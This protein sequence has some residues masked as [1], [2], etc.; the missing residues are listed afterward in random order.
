[1]FGTSASKGGFLQWVYGFGFVCSLVFVLVLAGGRKKQ[2]GT[3]SGYAYKNFFDQSR[4]MGETRVINSP[5]RRKPGR[6][7][8]EKDL[9]EAGGDV[10]DLEAA[11]G[12]VNCF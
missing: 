10:I 1:M 3:P 11:Q 6:P 7:P 9:G 4:P 8:R 2:A 12:M 5:G